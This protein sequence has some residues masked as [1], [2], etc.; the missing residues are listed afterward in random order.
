LC[1]IPKHLSSLPVLSGVR[2][3]R[4]LVLYV[5]FVDRC[6]S[7]CPFSFGHCVVCSSSIYR[8]WLPPFGRVKVTFVSVFV[9]NELYIIMLIRIYFIFLRSTLF[10]YCISL[11][12]SFRAQFM[13]IVWPTIKFNFS[14]LHFFF[15]LQKEEFGDT[16][17]RYKSHFYSE[18]Q[19]LCFIFNRR[20]F[21]Y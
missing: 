21:D 11:I 18:E 14:L 13:L 5:C 7:F 3:T 19:S 17:G 10:V 6:L 8:F 2:V 12:M 16:K 1:T 15:N 4:S 9:Y 20:K